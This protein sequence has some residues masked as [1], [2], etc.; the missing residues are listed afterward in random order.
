MALF[1]RFF[2]VMFALCLGS[3]AAGATYFA[4]A[5]SF[6]GEL[7]QTYD[8]NFYWIFLFSAFVWS[9]FF[10]LW[11]YIP[12][13]IAVLI[14]EALSIRS[15]LIYAAAGAAGGALYGYSLLADL[16]HGVQSSAAAGIVGALVY[17]LFAGRSAGAWRGTPAKT[18]D[19]V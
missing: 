2:V 5:N 16:Q 12:I 10:F 13:F 11:S 9:T 6:G 4:A 1:F 17:W 15:A 3:F 14:T 8:G 7:E 18:A 19:P